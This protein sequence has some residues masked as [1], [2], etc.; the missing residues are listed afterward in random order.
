MV[1]QTLLIVSPAAGDAE[2]EML[3][4]PLTCVQLVGVSWLTP[5]AWAGDERS[6]PASRAQAKQP[7]RTILLT[8]RA[9]HIVPSFPPPPGAEPPGGCPA[10]AVPTRPNPFP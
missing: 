7:A 4:V 10:G 2:P 1:T 6:S 5:P 3:T 8:A 9:L